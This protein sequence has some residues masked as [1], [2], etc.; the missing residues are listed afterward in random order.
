MVAMNST[1]CPR[2]VLALAVLLLTAARLAA[3]GAA[4]ST[5]DQHGTIQRQQRFGR[6]SGRSAGRDDPSA[7]A[8][9][10][11]IAR[12]AHAQRG[13]AVDGTRARQLADG[14][15]Q[16]C[17]VRP[18]A[19]SSFPPATEHI[20]K[21]NCAT[22]WA[23]SRLAAASQVR[24]FEQRLDHFAHDRRHDGATWKQRVITCDKWWGAPDAATGRGRGPIWFYAGNEADI[25]LY[26]NNTGERALVSLPVL[27][28]HRALRPQRG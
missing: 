11:M 22:W 21:S 4:R 26:V 6:V 13:R 17:A 2:P 5:P 14:C 10:R 9:H 23:C 8:R 7:W 3:P 15:L 25:E 12:R 19:L 28:W 1:R 16:V 20:T 27:A 24:W 18:Q